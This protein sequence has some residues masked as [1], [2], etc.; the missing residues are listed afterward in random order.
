[1]L[2]ASFISTMKVDSPKEAGLETSAGYPHHFTVLVKWEKDALATVPEIS[3]GGIEDTGEV[4]AKTASSVELAADAAVFTIT[5]QQNPTNTEITVNG[6]SASAAGTL[7]PVVVYKP[8][9]T[10]AMA[11]AAVKNGTSLDTIIAGVK[12]VVVKNNNTYTADFVFVDDA[13]SGAIEIWASDGA[14]KDKVVLDFVN[15]GVRLAAMEAIIDAANAPENV[16]ELLSAAISSNLAELDGDAGLFNGLTEEG[17]KHVAA[18]VANEI[19]TIDKTDINNY[20]K[21]ADPIDAASLLAA[22]SEGKISDK[23]AERVLPNLSGT[24]LAATAV[25]DYKAGR[26]SDAG[27]A[28][29]WNAMKKDTGY[30]ANWSEAQAPFIEQVFV[31]TVSNPGKNGVNDVAAAIKAYRSLSE[32]SGCDWISYDSIAAAGKGNQFASKMMVKKPTSYEDFVTKF[33]EVVDELK[34]TPSK[35]GPGPSGGSGSG[36]GSGT[37]TTTTIDKTPSKKNIDS[38][39]DANDAAWAKSALQVML[40]KNIYEGYEDNTI[41]PNNNA[42]REEVIKILVSTFFTVNKNARSSFSDV[43]SNEWF[44][45]YVAT[46]EAKGITKGMGDGTFGVG[47]NVTRQDFAVMIYNYMLDKGIQVNTTPYNFVDDDAIADYARDA[48][49]ALKNAEIIKGYEDNTVVPEGSATRAEIAQ[50]VANLIVLLGL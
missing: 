43:A 41:R 45:P 48:I 40:D 12:Q 15:P 34:V 3:D 4:A 38:F 16:A 19:K 25:A 26:I 24:G 27:K 9:M 32:L 21:V 42:T 23:D 7:V 30:Y 10:P 50:M 49:Y 18:S 28:I 39:K 31:N 2:A 35:P 29:L 44:Y 36:S 37:G 47:L 20:K 8:G 46:G 17:K 13:E 5:A 33:N 1:M 14:S 22:L 11:D 6:T